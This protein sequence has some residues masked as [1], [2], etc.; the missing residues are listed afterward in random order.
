M[1]TPPQRAPPTHRPARW[2]EAADRW[3]APQDR[4]G[5]P[6]RH[7]GGATCSRWS[8]SRARRSQRRTVDG[9]RPRP[10]AMRRWP[11]PAALADRA[12]PTTSVASASL[13]WHHDGSNTRV[14]RQSRHR[15]RRGRTAAA[16]PS[17]RRT[18]RV[19]AHD[20]GRNGPP[21]R[22]QPI[23]PATRSAS[24][25]SASSTTI[26]AEVCG[27]QAS[28]VHHLPPGTGVPWCCHPRPHRPPGTV[29]TRVCPPAPRGRRPATVWAIARPTSFVAPVTTSINHSTDD[30]RPHR[31]RRKRAG[32]SSSN[33]RRDTCPETLP[34]GSMAES[35][36][37]WVSLPTAQSSGKTCALQPGR[38]GVAAR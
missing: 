3:Q 13:G 31:Q 36:P 19:R 4:A 29:R 1:R 30:P 11:C 9:A 38:S 2:V 21:H 14:A 6:V 23:R 5:R 25:R 26:T 34:S 7:L 28:L 10:A 17:N 8:P 18:R 15:P 12:A 24:A 37:A 35:R 33:V 27:H 32:S 20:H 22:G 16:E